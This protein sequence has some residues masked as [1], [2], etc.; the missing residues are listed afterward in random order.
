MKEEEGENNFGTDVNVLQQA[1][2]D[3]DDAATDPFVDNQLDQSEIQSQASSIQPVQNINQ[4]EIN[5]INGENIFEA[6]RDVNLED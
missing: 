5:E 4:E 2:I 3:E 1:D 6:L